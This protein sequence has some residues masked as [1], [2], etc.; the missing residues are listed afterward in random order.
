MEAHGQRSGDLNTGRQGVR[1]SG[2]SSTSLLCFGGSNPGQVTENT[3][4]FGWLALG[5]K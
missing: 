5:Q 4:Q 3:E 2:S 1:G